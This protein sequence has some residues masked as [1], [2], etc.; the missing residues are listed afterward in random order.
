MT[1]LL[2][3]PLVG[4]LCAVACALAVAVPLWPRAD[5]VRASDENRDGRPDIWRLYDRQGQLAS[6]A[7]D[8]NFDGRSDV[9][10][11]YDAGVL[12]RRESDRDFNDQV[13]LVEDFDAASREPVRAVADVDFDGTADLFELFEDGRPVYVKWAHP[14]SAAL[15]ASREP[16]HDSAHTADAA[17]VGFDNPFRSDLA[18]RAVRVEPLGGQGIFLAASGGLP[19]LSPDGAGHRP[20]SP[21]TAAVPDALS[22]IVAL[23]SSRGP[24]SS[25]PS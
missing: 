23:R 19:S 7:I 13:D 14:P 22:A 4:R 12:V 25:L 6:V 24:P 2:R 17:L 8:T 18:V 16:G 5:E 9:T 10:E 1:R 21:S 15:T 11:Y 20:S 3:H